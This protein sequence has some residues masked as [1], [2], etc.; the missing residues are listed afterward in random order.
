MTPSSGASSDQQVL[1]Y[2]AGKR[3]EPVSSARIAIAATLAWLLAEKADFGMSP[4]ALESPRT[5]AFPSMRDFMLSGWTGA[6]PDSSVSPAMAAMRPAVWAGITLQ[7]STFCAT[8][9]TT[10]S[11]LSGRTATSAPPNS[12]L[13]H[14]I[15]PS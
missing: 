14:S 8:P 2:L 11:M 1:E 6:Q 7:Q 9:S 4:W 5:Q 3:R 10:T 12:G 15:M 13:I